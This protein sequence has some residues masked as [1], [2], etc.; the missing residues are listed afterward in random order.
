MR[1]SLRPRTQ[2][3]VNLTSLIDV[4]L[5]L[6]IFFMVSTSF[7]KQS[8]ISISLPQADSAAIV[9]E[10]PQQIDIMITE[11]GTFLVNGRELINSRVETIRNALQ[12]ISGGNN[13]LPLTISADANAKHQDVVTA[14]DVAGR[15][16]FKKISIATV[17]DPAS[18]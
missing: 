9:E 17:N 5:L 14:M 2:P 16:G 13:T 15:L 6:L 4:V 12:K 1:L 7:V 18:E 8:Q 3:E 11:T 10:V